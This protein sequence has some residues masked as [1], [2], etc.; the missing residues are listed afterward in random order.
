MVFS[1][2]NGTR[3][4]TSVMGTA[5]YLDPDEWFM[6][7]FLGLQH[8]FCAVSCQ[9]TQCLEMKVS[10]HPERTQGSNEETGLNEEACVTISPYHSSPG[11]ISRCSDS[12][13]AGSM[14]APC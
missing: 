12:T 14:T 7:T 2:D 3:V 6:N 8:G 11:V 5:G 10:R 9:L 1:S 4:V 13:N